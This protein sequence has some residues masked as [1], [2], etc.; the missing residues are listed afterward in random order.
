MNNINLKKRYIEIYDPVDLGFTI[1][2]WFQ[3][4]IDMLRNWYDNLA[5]YGQDYLARDI[6]FRVR[7]DLKLT[8]PRYET[9]NKYVNM[10]REK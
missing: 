7:N 6:Q 3:I 4:D 9:N 8:H 10:K 1:K 5:I 2:P